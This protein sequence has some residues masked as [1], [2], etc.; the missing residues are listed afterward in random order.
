MSFALA[1]G[2]KRTAHTLNRTRTSSGRG[3]G[4][5]WGWGKAGEPPSSHGGWWMHPIESAPRDWYWP[6]TIA[7]ISTPDPY[8]LIAGG[9]GHRRRGCRCSVLPGVS[10]QVGSRSARE[11]QT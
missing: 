4:W 10:M 7:V 3:R 1:V 9:A 5:G 2:A 8:R 6:R 11:P